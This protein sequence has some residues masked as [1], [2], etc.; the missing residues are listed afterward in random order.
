MPHLNVKEGTV[1]LMSAKAKKP[2]TAVRIVRNILLIVLAAILV[3]LLGVRLFFRLS[4]AEYYLR[5]SRSFVIPG[6]NS[7]MTVQGLAYD[8]WG[9]EFYVTGYR[10]DGKA[11]QLST[12]SRDTGRETRRLWLADENGQPFLGHVG[13][14]AVS[15]DYVYIADENGLVVYDYREIRDAENGDTVKAHGVFST[16]AGDDALPV[17]F[18]HA[19]G[20][21]LY[22]GEFYREQN[23]PTPESHHYRTQAG[24]GNTALILVYSLDKSAQYGIAPTIERAYSAPGLVQG[25]CFDGEGRIC[26]STSYAVAFSHLTLY[27]AEKAEGEVT[28][29]GQTVPRYVLDRSSMHRSIKIAPMSEEIVYVDGRL[30]TMCES[31]SNKYIFGKFTSA[32]YCYAT[33]LSAYEKE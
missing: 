12:V 21:K 22:V 25:L 15:G 7:G 20:D 10:S 29:L 23:Y 8:E 13:G 4:V 9:K 28:V 32:R 24:D 1:D 26:L 19:E 14:V 18:V 31:A 5:S 17:A 3:L 11:S 2:R 33:D 6:L 30:Y 27:D 16:K